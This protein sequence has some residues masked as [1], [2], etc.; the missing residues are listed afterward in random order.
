[1]YHNGGLLSQM[2]TKELAE[3]VESKTFKRKTLN[4]VKN[5]SDK[6]CASLFILQLITFDF[7]HNCQKSTRISG[8]SS[9]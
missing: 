1:M 6:L 2:P 4:N 5:I 8:A 3:K 7:Q 9:N